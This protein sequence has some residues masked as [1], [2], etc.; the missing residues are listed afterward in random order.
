MSLIKRRSATG[1][2]KGKYDK[3]AHVLQKT[4]WA[5]EFSVEHIKKI[6]S[7][8]E[9]VKA[10]PGAIVF[11]EGDT[12]KSLGIIVKGAIDI[13]KE[14]TKVTHPDQFPDLWRNGPD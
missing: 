12:D 5:S 13:I 3:Y 8:I 7:Y 4:K 10:D 11:K 6:C 1:L 2:S 14:N 9:P